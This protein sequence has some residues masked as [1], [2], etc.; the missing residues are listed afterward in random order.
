MEGQE[1]MLLTTNGGLSRE[2]EPANGR[3]PEPLKGVGAQDR[4]A[5][6]SCL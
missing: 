1:L 5:T 3:K 6:G 4:R 2:K